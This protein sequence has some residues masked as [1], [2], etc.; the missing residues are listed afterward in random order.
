VVLAVAMFGMGA[1]GVGSAS[2]V[3]TGWSWFPPGTY[4]KFSEGETSAIVQAGVGGA[5]AYV[6]AKLPTPPLKAAAAV[7]GV[8]LWLSARSALESADQKCMIIMVTVWR[9]ASFPAEC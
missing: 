1:V 8:S 7:L 5:A 9:Q 4:A 6:S 3:E 2:A